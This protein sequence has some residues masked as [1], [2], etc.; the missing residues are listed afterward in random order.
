MASM[1]ES[2]ES[3]LTQSL[4]DNAD[5]RTEKEKTEAIISAYQEAKVLW[6]KGYHDHK[7]QEARNAAWIEVA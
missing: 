7:N 3:V 2:F 5:S 6:F 4:D 1:S